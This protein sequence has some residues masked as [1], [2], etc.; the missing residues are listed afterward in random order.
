MSINSTKNGLNYLNDCQI[1]QALVVSA[2]P[3]FDE[4]MDEFCHYFDHVCDLISKYG[5]NIF[6]N[7]SEPVLHSLLFRPIFS[8]HFFVR[9]FD[10]LDSLKLCD[11]GA[12]IEDMKL[13]ITV[14]KRRIDSF[15]AVQYERIKIAKQTFKFWNLPHNKSLLLNN[16]LYL[17]TRRFVLDSEDVHLKVV[18]KTYMFGSD[19][20]I[21]FEDCLVFIS[22]LEQIYPLNLIWLSPFET[23]NKEK[24]SFKIVTPEREIKVCTFEL[25]DRAEWMEK[26]IRCVAEYLKCPESAI[27]VHRYG[28]FNFTNKSHKLCNF[29]VEGNWLNGKFY[30]NC[31]IKS[32][33]ISYKCRIFEPFGELNGI[34]KIEASDYTYEGEFEDGKMEGYGHW[35]N[36][37][38]TYE[39]YFSKDKF[40]G[41]GKL[42]FNE[43]EYQG[44][45]MDGLR[46]GYG[47]E[48]NFDDGSKYIGYWQD[49]KKQGPGILIQSDGSNFEGVFSQNNLTGNGLALFSNGSY[50][51]GEMTS[52]DSLNGYG[53]LCNIL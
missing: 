46:C 5:L 8:L 10:L 15:F 9:T 27:P 49:D 6:E 35:K 30:T 36:Y 33:E 19:R 41:H 45:F 20:F 51:Q 42:I 7:V 23:M 37:T 32:P 50:Y 29:H 28:S 44:K 13:K 24:Y 17:K 22:Q 4:Y 25:Q 47:I 3:L 11:D 39:G 2:I 48:N 43:T 31:H 53:M 34:G 38:M 1:R 21:L 18:D 40:H 14:R 52:V 12:D 26:I 16:E